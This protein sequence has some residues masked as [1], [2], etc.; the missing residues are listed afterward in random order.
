LID[1][2]EFETGDQLTAAQLYGVFGLAVSTEIA[3]SV[4]VLS[5]VFTGAGGIDTI[6]DSAGTDSSSFG[7][8]LKKGMLWFGH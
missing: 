6:V 3:V 7:D 8:G 4:G 5:T 2:F 1:V